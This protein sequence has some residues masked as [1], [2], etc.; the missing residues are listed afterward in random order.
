[1]TYDDAANL[2]TTVDCRPNTPYGRIHVGVDKPLH[3][4]E[5]TNLFTPDY[6]GATKEV[7]GEDDER[8]AAD[9]RHIQ[10]HLAN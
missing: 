4:L 3:K 2:L 1:V 10:S 9:D 7:A 8:V 6:L 5:W